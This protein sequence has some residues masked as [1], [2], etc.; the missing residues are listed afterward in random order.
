[1]KKIN[2]KGPIVASS[3]K[4]IYDWLGME[5]TSPK[6]FI[7]TLEE[8]SG[9]DVEVEINSGGGNLFAGIEIAAAIEKYKGNILTDVVGMAASA[10]SIIAVSTK[11]RMHHAAMMVVHNVQSGANGDYHAMD[12]ESYSLQQANAAVAQAYVRKT[13]RTPEEVLEIMDRESWITAQEAL[14]MGLCDEILQDASQV[15]PPLVNAVD[16]G[17]LPQ[18]VIE[19]IRNEMPNLAKQAEEEKPLEN[20]KDALLIEKEKMNLIKLQEVK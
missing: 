4:W 14:D 13:G 6:D 16:S 11:C 17:M 3:E 2:V 9:D 1:M 15:R 20:A 8:A 5:A 10:A 19:K 7:K 18:A 12:Q